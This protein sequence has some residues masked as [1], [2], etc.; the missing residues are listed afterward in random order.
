MDKRG[1]IFIVLALVMASMA[2]AGVY[3]YLKTVPGAEARAPETSPV[4]VASSDLTFGTTLKE[5]HLKVVDFPKAA[6]PAGSYTSVDSV[7][8]QTTK[9]FV[10]AGEPVL[11]SKLSAI[12][13]G[14]S[15]RVPAD[16]RAMSLKVNEV[17]GVSGFVLPGDRVDI[18]VT[19]DNA[20][21][22]MNAVTNTILQDLEVL[23]AGVKTETKNNQNVTVQTV[24]VLVNPDGA[25]KLAL[26]V[27]QGS[28][29][30]SLRNPV[31]RSIT[32]ATSKDVRTVM[33]M[34]SDKPDTKV[35]Y[36]QAPVKVTAAE[37]V[38][39][40]EEQ[41]TFTVIRNGKIE[42]QESPVPAKDKD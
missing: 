31:D 37:P 25:E 32:Q 36:R 11:A 13:G 16:M 6:V 9:V 29:H 22:S 17:T 1:L 33:G 28:V 4:V 41:P 18:L 14:L 39:V 40:K 38:P 23:A 30:L 10:V 19:I 20:A 27:D 3:L 26:A 35:V 42:K 21:G 34:K 12:G 24:T 7:L 2:A 15:V 8:S 5:E